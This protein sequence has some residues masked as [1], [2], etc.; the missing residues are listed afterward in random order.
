MYYQGIFF[1][2]KFPT[3]MKG[4]NELMSRFKRFSDLYFWDLTKTS[5]IIHA[6]E[7]KQTTRKLQKLPTFQSSI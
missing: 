4:P 5:F 2:S 6:F 3:F 7:M 1:S